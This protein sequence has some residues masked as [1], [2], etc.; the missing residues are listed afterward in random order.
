MN[1]EP[2]YTELTDEV[3]AD[4]PKLLQ[5][6][7][8]ESRPIEGHDDPKAIMECWE[9]VQEITELMIYRCQRFEGI[10]LGLLETI[11]AKEKELDDLKESESDHTTAV[12]TTGIILAVYKTFATLFEPPSPFDVLP[13]SV[14]IEG[15][16][17]DRAVLINGQFLDPGP[18]LAVD[19]ASPD[20]FNWGFGGSGPSQLALAIL[21][22]CGMKPSIAVRYKN[23]FKFGWVGGLPK[24]DFIKTINLRQLMKDLVAKEKE[25]LS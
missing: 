6:I 9:S 20:G 24:T 10:R 2:I 7:L 3:L 13:L 18:S 19:N 12:K 11:A 1:K 16:Y 5:A 23:T 17:M 22:H 21:M 25:K 14:T 15:A 8:K 4:F